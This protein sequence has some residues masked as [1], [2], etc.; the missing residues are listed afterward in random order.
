MNFKTLI[1]TAGVLLSTNA[2]YTVARTVPTIISPKI[3][4]C[5]PGV[6]KTFHAFAMNSDG[7]TLKFSISEVMGG[8]AVFTKNNKASA[9]ISN[10]SPG[11]AITEIKF[12][13]NE[14]SATGC[15]CLKL[16]VTNGT[17][18]KDEQMIKFFAGQA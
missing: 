8:S 13:P 15:Y 2:T 9:N 1:L 11:I 4:P 14:V 10:Y 7:K 16:T 5:N 3:Y 6:A 17:V 12:T 18:K